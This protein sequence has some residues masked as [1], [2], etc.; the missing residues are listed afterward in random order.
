MLP[1][2]LQYFL[3]SISVKLKQSYKPGFRQF[4]KHR[5]PAVGGRLL[6]ISEKCSRLEQRAFRPLTCIFKCLPTSPSSL[7]ADSPNSTSKSQ[8]TIFLPTA[9][10]C[11]SP[12]SITAT[13]TLTPILPVKKFYRFYLYNALYTHLSFPVS[14]T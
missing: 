3:A 1:I 8:L 9:S 4:F 6:S 13:C 12:I 14:P 10:L 2:T 7:P 11:D 5:G